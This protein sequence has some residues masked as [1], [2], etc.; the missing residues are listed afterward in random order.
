MVSFKMFKK[1]LNL[2]KWAINSEHFEA[3][4][5]GVLLVAAL[6]VFTKFTGN[7]TT[8]PESL[9]KTRP[10]HRCF[11][12]NFAKFSR[13]N[14]FH[15]KPPVSASENLWILVLD[16]TSFLWGEDASWSAVI[17]LWKNWK[18]FEKKLLRSFLQIKSFKQM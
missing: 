8:V 7:K 2:Q 10:W 6:K 3:V 5:G 16:R 14:I 4:I 12:V 18:A 11:C 17:L 13:I 1:L 9:L 15:R